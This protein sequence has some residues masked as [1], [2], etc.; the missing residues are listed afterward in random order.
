M[1]YDDVDPGA[2]QR[3]GAGGMGV[4]PLAGRRAVVAGRDGGAVLS[5]QFS[6]LSSQFSV[7]SFDL[8]AWFCAT[9]AFEVPA[10]GKRLFTFPR[11][12]KPRRKIRARVWLNPAEELM[13]TIVF[14]I[15]DGF[16]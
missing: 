15:G 16:F 3:G 9:G 1:V 2:A 6:V 11:S 8:N 14:L 12:G 5:S 10:L 7:L 4:L 13:A